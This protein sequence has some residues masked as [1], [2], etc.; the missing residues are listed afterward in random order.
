[1]EGRTLLS[2]AAPPTVVSRPI[3]IA[4]GPTDEPLTAETALDVFPVAARATTSKHP[5]VDARRQALADRRAGLAVPPQGPIV[6]GSSSPGE[7]AGEAGK[8]AVKTA[9]DGYWLVHSKDVAKVGLDYAKTSVSHDTRKVGAAYIK[10]ALKGDTDTLKALGNTRAVK[11]VGQNFTRL[12]HS[13]AVKK[14]GDK[15]SAFGR[16]VADEFHK[17]FG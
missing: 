9:W 6:Q 11:R 8:L 14:L 4:A 2:T 12:T 7:S 1:M 15:F 5:F 10:A 3:P 16:S 17:I 13:P